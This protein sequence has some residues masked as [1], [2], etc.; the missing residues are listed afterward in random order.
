MAYS[1]GGVKQE[2]YDLAKEYHERIAP[3][4][5]QIKDIC[6]ELKLPLLI[7]VQASVTDTSHSIYTTSSLN[8]VSTRRCPRLSAARELLDPR[9]NLM[10]VLSIMSDTATDDEPATD[11]EL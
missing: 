7:G 1:I 3:L 11:V 8:V 4:A 9:C 10:Q 5:A 6:D 2:K